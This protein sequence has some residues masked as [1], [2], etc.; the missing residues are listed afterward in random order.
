MEICDMVNYADDNTLNV[1]KR[2]VQML[3]S[4]L[5]KDTE[6]AMNWS[7]DNFMQANPDKFQFM[8]LKKYTSKEI[9]PKFIEIHGTEIKCEKEVKHLGITIDEKL[10]FDTHINNL[11]KKAAMQI[12]VMY[13]FKSIFDLK[14]RDRIYNTFILSNFNYCPIIWHFCGKLSSKK[15]ENI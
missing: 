4:A 13:R 14:E 3:L 6:N 2:T 10:K 7:K 9:V 11:Y 1:I 5:K 15:I 8:F 12:N